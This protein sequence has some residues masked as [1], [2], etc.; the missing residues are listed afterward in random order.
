[1]SPASPA[2]GSRLRRQLIHCTGARTAAS[3]Y[4]FADAAATL[5]D[6][7]NAAL[8]EVGPGQTLTTLAHQQ[9]GSRAIPIVA[10]MPERDGAD[11]ASGSM[12]D[13][14]GR[15]WAAGLEPDWNALWNNESQ[16]RV[17]LPTYPFER[18]KHWIEPP[19]RQTA[20]TITPVVEASA[21]TLMNPPSRAA[22][23]VPEPSTEREAAMS[24]DAN[25][26]T[27]ER[28]IRLQP[29][30]ANLFEELS[31]IATGPE[32]FDTS[33]LE[34]GFDSLFLTQVTQSLQRKFGV[35][36]TFRQIVEQFSTITS[37]SERLDAI[38]PAEAFPAETPA[39]AAPAAVSIS[40]PTASAPV[41]SG[42]AGVGAG[43]GSKS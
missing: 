41:F 17:S 19:T 8:L 4:A 3:L 28:R 15:L 30:V 2:H 1:M 9:R 35:K 21:Q 7:S 39:A 29:I 37:L 38:L 5:L 11:L 18:K 10:S 13:A 40:A 34:L 23:P 36:V 22:E 20:T 26:S 6:F 43:S 33:F 25:G 14:L 27:A 24:N 12:M 16:Q 31:G 32:T 42:P